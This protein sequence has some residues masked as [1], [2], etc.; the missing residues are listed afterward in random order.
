MGTTTRLLVRAGAAAMIPA[1]LAGC[2]G[3]GSEPAPA[4]ASVALSQT[5]ATLVPLPP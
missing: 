2:G 4:V 3:G 5:A 1:L